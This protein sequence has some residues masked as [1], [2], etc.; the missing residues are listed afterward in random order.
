MSTDK[1]P[2]KRLEHVEEYITSAE[3]GTFGLESHYNSLF[4]SLIPR[5]VTGL[6]KKK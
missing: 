2:S 5:V 4:G 6:L 3:S 1:D